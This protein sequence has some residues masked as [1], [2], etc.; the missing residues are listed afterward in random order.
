MCIC[1]DIKDIITVRKI[2]GMERF[3]IR[4]MFCRGVKLQAVTEYLFVSLYNNT[5]AS[6]YGCEKWF[7]IISREAPTFRTCT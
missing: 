2:H 5:H 3:K 7:V 6:L 4:V 1:W